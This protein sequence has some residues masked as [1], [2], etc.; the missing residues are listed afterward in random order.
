M[1]MITYGNIFEILANSVEI[2]TKI[3]FVLHVN[4]NLAEERK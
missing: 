2:S 4:R 1:Y 3:I